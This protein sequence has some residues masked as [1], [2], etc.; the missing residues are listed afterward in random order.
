MTSRIRAAVESGDAAPDA[1]ADPAARSGGMLR[2][3]G[4]PA[5]L[6]ILAALAAFHPMI[7]SGFALT[8]GDLGDAR[9]NNYVLEHSYRWL[10]GDPAHAS[11]WNMP[12][13]FPAPRALLYSDTLLGAAPIFWLFR[14]LGAAPDTAFQLWM[15]AVSV[16]TFAACWL[17]LRD[18]L[19]VG[20]VAAAGGAML[21]A[22]A[23]MRMSQVGH[24]QL[25]A[26]FY[27][28]IAAWAL[29]RV[30]RGARAGRSAP[31]MLLAAGLATT[32]QAYTGFYFFWF[33]LF[34]MGALSLSVL[35]FGAA[36]AQ[37]V[38]AVRL[39]AAWVMAT[40]AL[41]A[42]L[43][44]PLAYGYRQVVLQLG[45]RDYAQVSYYLA[46]IWAWFCFGESNWLYGWIAALPP[47]Q[48]VLFLGEKQ[49][50]LG[51]VTLCC[52]FAGSRLLVRRPFGRALVLASAGIVAAM[53]VIAGRYSLW[54]L[55][56]HFVPAAAAVR[57]VARMGLMVLLPASIA[58]A[59]WLEHSRRWALLL[60]CLCLLEQMQTIR[61]HDKDLNRRT[62]AEI[63]EPL[64]HA[65][66]CRAFIYSQASGDYPEW[67]YQIDA[68]W[69]Q[70]AAG[71]PTLNGYSG[72]EPPDW[73]LAH[74]AP[75]RPAEE[76]ALRDQILD[77]MRRRALSPGDVC[78][79]RR[80]RKGAQAVQLMYPEEQ[81]DQAMWAL[82][83][84]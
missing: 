49:L 1:D 11:L 21:F 30:V 71:I 63:A 76:T 9:F 8:P 36:R 46:P 43:L 27:P 52:V 31:G 58:F 68:M 17:L 67:K 5:V 22:F 83:Q 19:R 37:V 26:H 48:D 29:L 15:L 40:A 16:L 54:P 25:L 72:N 78:W 51:L 41:C 75:R 82:L 50:G 45:Y 44:L 59:V 39:N 4:F 56:Y 64:R 13:F 81:L 69:V 53:T 14:V 70:L 20:P 38:R 80:F 23:S 84:K 62:V 34:A 66:S 28:P 35:W 57:A 65:G 7:F 47:F 55:V 60:I 32:A 18:G 42:A 24:Q 10:R 77:W 3:L 2:E 12:I 61:M 6:C 79:L 33:F 73:P 74:A